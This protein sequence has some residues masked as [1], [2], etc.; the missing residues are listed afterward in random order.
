MNNSTVEANFDEPKFLSSLK[1]Q[2][3]SNCHLVVNDCGQAI[4]NTEDRSRCGQLD[5]DVV[6]LVMAINKQPEYRTTSSCAGR[7]LVYQCASGVRKRGCKWLLT[8]HSELEWRQVLR[9]ATSDSEV[10][11]QPSAQSE[12]VMT[13]FKYE[14]FILHCS[15]D[16]F[17]AARVLL[18][19][20][21]ASGFRE[22]GLVLG[23]CRKQA[24]VAAA[25]WR[26]TV[27]VRSA[28]SLDI[29]LCDESGR[30][31]VTE[32]YLRLTVELGNRRLAENALK[33]DRFLAA[34]HHKM[35]LRT[36]VLVG[37]QPRHSHSQQSSQKR[38]PVTEKE[39]MD[40]M[41]EQAADLFQ[42]DIY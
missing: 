22:S 34:F 6:D 27:A 32:D 19:C 18:Q 21:L 15:C 17:D 7:L 11:G 3:G 38:K 33:R 42:Q 37:S 30:L 41:L 29:P 31:L 4:L 8:S 2:K 28:T 13:W 12:G 23:S 35:A 26:L 10:S 5:A 14:A 39:D 9:I 25:P 16:T 24:P 40:D 20:A 1:L 36:E